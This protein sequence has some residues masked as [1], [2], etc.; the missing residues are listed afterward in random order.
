[1][2]SNDFTEVN[3]MEYMSFMSK[4]ICS[5]KYS[6]VNNSDNGYKVCCINGNG[7]VLAYREKDK[8][9]GIFRNYIKE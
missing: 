8:E 2:K 6:L 4:L 9:K 3:Q 7:D 1:M 5:G